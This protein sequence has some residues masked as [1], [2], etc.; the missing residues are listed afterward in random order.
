[1]TN[2]TDTHTTPAAPSVADDDPDAGSTPVLRR[3]LF[4]C[5][6]AF[7]VL[8]ICL[9]VTRELGGA[10]D[11]AFRFRAGWFAV[12]V[13]GFICL[14]VLHAEFW[15][16]LVATMGFPVRVPL[17]WSI[18]S[19]STI[20]RYAPTGMLMIVARVALG[21]RAGIPRRESTSAVLHEAAMAFVGALAL[22]ATFFV[23][24]DAWADNPARFA[25]LAIPVLAVVALHPRILDAAVDRLLRRLRREPL[26]RTVA[27]PIATLC[28][29]TAMYAASF[30]LAG[31]S[32][33]ALVQALVGVPPGAIVTIVAAF[34]VGYNASVLG[35]VIPGGIGVR[36]AG[37]AAALTPVMPA[38]MA[39]AVA[40]AVR[41]IQ[42][43]I[44]VLLAMVAT[45]W[46]K[47]RGVRDA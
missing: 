31:L 13:T 40:I 17:G 45:L 7:V 42:L 16:R 26:D 2:V 18:W 43:A 39:V 5:S 25:I 23:Q 44:E 27:I 21:A 3:V 1:M 33:Y 28:R 32:L 34:A 6:A 30:A 47:R 38:A 19:V 29:F 20:A 11:F 9:V 46:L 14:H 35:A 24:L 12:A 37:L 4:A 10:E 36:E 22:S 15:R 41:L 8:S